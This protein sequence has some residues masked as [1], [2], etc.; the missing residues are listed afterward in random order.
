[1]SYAVDNNNIYM[2]SQ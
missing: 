1:M 2:L